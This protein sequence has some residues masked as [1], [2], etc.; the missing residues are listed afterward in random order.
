MAYPYIPAKSVS[1][2]GTRA[3]NSVKYIVIHYTGNDNDTAL[4]NCNFFKNS[5][6]RSAG[7]HWF[8][9]RSGAVYQS[10]D[11]KRIAWSVGGFFTQ[12]NGAG[13]YYKKCTNTNSVSI[14]MCDVK[15]QYP[16]GAQVS[17]IKKLI[18]YIQSEC[19]NAKT[20]IRHWDVNGKSC[21]ARMTGTNNAEWKKFYSQ[22]T[23][24][25][26]ISSG[27]TSTSK[28]ASTSSSSTSKPSKSNKID[29]DGQ[30]GKATTKAAQIVFKTYPDGIVSKQIAK[31]KKYMPACLSSS[32]QFLDSGYKGGSQLIK[33][34]QK[35]LGV[36]QDG[37]VGQG[38]IKAL[39]KKLGVTA[40]GY[41]GKAT[42]TAWQKYLN[43]Y[44]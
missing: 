29:V 11:M 4:A 39:Q 13:S 31:Y 2:G 33:A 41:M 8:V 42:V 30:W 6:T 21:P 37:L 3:L 32:W 17:A 26:A 14:E 36:S 28:P 25:T 9:D 19:P 35:W 1:Y 16:S 15:N 34:I 12:S 20:I 44:L 43:K 7:C 23:G 38:T 10:I 24:K 22:I 40:D 5:N 18:A 27:S